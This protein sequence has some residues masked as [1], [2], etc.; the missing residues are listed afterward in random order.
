[1]LLLPLATPPMAGP[2]IALL[3]T[4]AGN[5]LIV[6]SIANIIVVDSAARHGIRIDWRRH[7]R[8]GVPE[9]FVALAIAAAYLW[10]RVGV[11]S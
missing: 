6:G 11:T 10:L 3:S 1:M 5:L 2:V 8:V 4:L 7:A 9:T